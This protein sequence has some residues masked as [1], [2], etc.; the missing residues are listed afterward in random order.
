LIEKDCSMKGVQEA[1]TRSRLD[2]A[3]A[4]LPALAEAIGRDAAQREARR[5]LPFEGFTL[6]RASGLGAIRL[7]VEWG[8]LGGT[9]EDLFE[10]VA[11]LAAHDSNLSHAL[12]I[13]FD[14][15]ESL[16]LSPHSA[17]ND[18]QIERVR[19]GALFGGASTERT[20]ARPG[21]ISIK[22]RAD[23]E[24][25][26][27]T[28]KKYYST[29]TLFSDYARI[30]VR[31]ENDQ[32]VSI[33]IPVTREGLKIL[34]DWDGMGQ[35]MT[36]SGSLVLEDVQV[37]AN[38]IAKR[39]Y[40]TL[41]GRH[42]GALRQLHLVAVAAGIVRN[43]VSDAKHY[44]LEHGRIALHG[45]AQTPREDAVVQQVIGELAAS[46]LAIDALV[47]ENA[48]TLDR[49][50]NAIRSGAKNAEAL[51]LEGSLATAKTQFVISKLA[52]HAAERLFEIGGA[53]ATSR[54]HNL[55]RHWRNLRTI[56]SHNPLLHKARVIGD[57]ELNGTTTHLLEGRVF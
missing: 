12:R 20:T 10:V 22:L 24:H 43:I 49:S 55:D 35:R 44:V 52:L 17:L 57:Y 19:S 16:L 21:E 39:G 11:T 26:R 8:G 41:A 25:F 36:A 6:F 40:Q 13:H 29:G 27:V 48:R 32:D 37:F 47:R 38:E 15:T 50:A 31:D 5:A 56:F 2:D 9:L 18:V 14:L 42:G 30:N 23:G 45:L 46:S 3:L 4:Q 28:G 34:D 51:V 1:S 7:P 53:S 54:Q 33:I